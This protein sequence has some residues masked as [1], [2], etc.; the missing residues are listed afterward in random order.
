[1]FSPPLAP[2]CSETD[3]IEKYLRKAISN[4]GENKPLYIAG[5]PGTGK[6]ACVNAVVKT[7][8]SEV[9]K[10]ILP[11]FEFI[12]ING[13]KLK[14]PQD[15]Y[16]S[17]WME[18]TGERLG[19]KTAQVRLDNL[20]RMTDNRSVRGLEDQENKTIIL[21]L[22]DELDFLMKSD[23]VV[24]NLFDWP[25]Y[26]SNH[27]CLIVVGISNMMD[28][29]ARFSTRVA[30][31]L[32]SGL[33][34]LVFAP[35]THK[36]IEEIINTRLEGL[37]IF[38]K[39]GLEYLARKS[40]S[41]GDLRAALKVCQRSIE[42]FRDSLSSE[43]RRAGNVKIGKPFT[44]IIAALTEHNEKPILASLSRSCLL[45]KAI[46]VSMY[47]EYI[48]S[49]VLGMTSHEI[50]DRFQDLMEL[51]SAADNPEL[52][53][54][55]PPM[56]IFLGRLNHMCDTGLLNRNT[57]KTSGSHISSCVLSSALHMSDTFAYF[58]KTPFAPLIN[59][60]VGTK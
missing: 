6:T 50:W 15:A 42:I 11:A 12:S 58:A 37:E 60:T 29:P 7:L 54:T 18:I 4:K 5:A 16:S 1:M 33:E 34:S 10:G 41:S 8:K 36:Q 2:P 31:R 27:A 38:D 32:K 51:I 40:A 9:G 26:S 43:L 13:L 25:Q 59:P 22:V 52:D 46:H 30:S 39:M 45:D 24:Y 47:K 3:T 19:A 55:A 57:D 44:P 49:G 21:C 48:S 14:T 35:Y 23:S 53:L 56:S 20:F 17:L 28:L